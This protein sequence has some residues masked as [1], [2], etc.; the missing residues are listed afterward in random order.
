MA[1]LQGVSDMASIFDIFSAGPAQQAAQD[2]QNALLTGYTQLGNLYGQG[3]QALQQNYMAGLQPF[4]QNFGTAQQGTAALGNALGLNGPQGNAAATQAFMNNPGYQFQ[5]NQATNAVDRNAAA[6]GRLNSG[7][8]NVDL[9]NY[10]SGLAGQGWQQYLGNLQPYLGMAQNSA[11]GI[12]NLYSGLGG[13]LN[14]NLTGQGQAA[15]GT[16]AG[17]GNAQA[18]AQLA[19]Y[20]PG[21]NML[22]AILGLGKTAAS[23][24]GAM[25]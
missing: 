4:L 21:A 5:V 22:G 6:Q 9:A 13:A 15:Y 7:N 1:H 16:E 11:A 19:N 12:G 10:I 20:I 3:S 18:Q 14:Q 24:A 23:V 8:T 25:G 2:Q 17:I